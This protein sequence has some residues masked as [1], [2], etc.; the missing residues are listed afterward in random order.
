MKRKY[1]EELMANGYRRKPIS[2]LKYG[3]NH[4]SCEMKK[5]SYEK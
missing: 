4:Q 3:E 2:R 5:I 1:E